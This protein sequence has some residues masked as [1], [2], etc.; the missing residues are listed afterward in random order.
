M[1]PKIE[2]FFQLGD[3]THQWSQ[4]D[5]ERLGEI[6]S[7]DTETTIIEDK[8]RVP[9][10]CLA[11]VS[12]GTRHFILRPE[13]LPEF[14]ESNIDH[15]THI[16]FHNVAFDFWVIDKWLC[17]SKASDARDILWTA[18]DQHRVHDT[19]LLGLLIDLAEY[20]REAYSS[21][22]NACKNHIGM[23]LEKDQFRLGFNELRNSPWDEIDPGFF[24]YAVTDAAA[25]WLL[26]EALTRK[27]MA[28]CDEFALTHQHGLL[29][30]AIQVKAA[31]G[32]GRITQ[33]GMK[34]DLPAV[35]KLRTEIESRIKTI[36]L[37]LQDELRGLWKT[38]RQTG[39]VL[40][41]EKTNAPQQNHTVLVAFFK[42]LAQ[43]HSIDLPT[44]GTGRISLSLG[45]FWN[46]YSHVDHRLELLCKLSDLSKSSS[47][48]SGLQAS[49]IHPAYS[50]IKRTGRTSCS[51]PNIQQMPRDEAIRQSIIADP[52]H[53]LFIIDY[54]CLELRTLAHICMQR[55]GSSKLGEVMKS[56]KDPHSYTAAIF[57]NMNIDE[58]NCR[59]DRKK[60]RQH[61][62][63][64]NFGIPG[65]LGT[66]S[67]VDFAKKQ[68]EVSISLEDAEFFKNKLTREIYPEL[69]L[70]LGE[71]DTAK[72]AAALKTTEWE[73]R[74]MWPDQFYIV[75]LKKILA[76][77]PFKA[78]GTK[79]NPMSI[80]RI[81]RELRAV[82][83][84]ELFVP[85]IDARD[86]S[87]S[88]PLRKLFNG[89]VTTTTGRMR[90]SVDYSQ[91]RNT[92][93]QGLAADG[94][95][96]ALWELTKAGYRVVGFVHDEFIIEIPKED[97]FSRVAEDINRI[98]CQSMEI[99]VPGIPVVCEY[100]VSERWNKKAEAV[101]DDQGNLL[102][103]KGN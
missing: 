29:T 81:W 27:A 49:T 15:K 51:R 3:S 78:D 46:Q 20:D 11:T 103:W 37:Q 8:G 99:Y 35:E 89:P 76:E 83:R 52:G 16:V 75:M 50:T 23:Q 13:Q 92:P 2:G 86:S 63:V 53:V 4:W 7:I 42:E 28:I 9:D 71:D 84:N 77:K 87:K 19:M 1:Q 82:C 96:Q 74:A 34:V 102:L 73:L 31:I 21:L 38:S 36:E 5:G 10:I 66:K 32:L 59:A 100:A 95:K 101:Y 57:H 6:I 30:E 97:T 68:Y 56:G 39:E 79:Y 85:F 22:A 12:D 48:L 61:A 60:L 18:V 55:Y 98:C 14:L 26:Y 45:E 17:K 91:S 93:F 90:G 80:D 64:F 54:N 44:T 33:N 47:F 24:V 43:K 70:Y 67:I 41:T 94:C 58:F 25:T 62:K 40:R 88:S 65:G 72:L 69:A